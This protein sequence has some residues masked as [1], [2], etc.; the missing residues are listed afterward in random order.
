MAWLG[1]SS[2]VSFSELPS[3]EGESLSLVP[4]RLIDVLEPSVPRKYFLSAR[5]AEGVLRRAD[6]RDRTLDSDLEMALRELSATSAEE[7]T[8][9]RTKGR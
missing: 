8:M 7:P 5:A 3:D 2:T 1:E 4:V 6:K 9:G